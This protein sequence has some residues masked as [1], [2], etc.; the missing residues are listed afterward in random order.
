M[1]EVLTINIESSSV[2]VAVVRGRRML[3]WAEAP[4]PQGVVT[5]G[6]V[7]D[8]A[9]VSGVLGKLLD[10]I[11]ARRI[12]PIIGVSGLRSFYRYLTVPKMEK[13][14]L[15]KVVLHDLEDSVHV[16]QDQLYIN[17]ARVRGAGGDSRV[18]VVASPRSV[19]DSIIQTVRM[20]GLKMPVLDCKPLAL[21]RLA[22]TENCIMVDIEADSMQFVVVKKR[23]PM[24]IR[25]VPLGNWSVTELS[26]QLREEVDTTL[27]L[28][29]SAYPDDPV[30][31][32][33][34]VCI[35]GAGVRGIE[36]VKQLSDKL[37]RHVE[38]VT[39]VLN[40]L[41]G[42]P[43]PDYAVNMGLAMRPSGRILSGHN[44]VPLVDILPA[45]Y[46]PAPRP[47]KQLVLGPAVAAGILMVALSYQAYEQALFR[48]ELAA[49]E[50]KV[51]QE[52]M[53][54]KQAEAKKLNDLQQVLAQTETAL[55]TVQAERNT[56]VPEN[57]Q[58]IGALG[59]IYSQSGDQIMLCTVS[60]NGGKL[61]I[62]GAALDHRSVLNYAERLKASK[63]FTKIDIRESSAVVLSGEKEHGIYRFGAGEEARVLVKGD[64]VI[65]FTIAAAK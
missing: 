37:Q 58:F 10:S 51:V 20:A 9:A 8:P 46:R 42:M 41:D 22:G 57:P 28:Y 32:G 26:E 18:F 36:S 40:H 24:V 27:R 5:G 14:L 12:R 54:L 62:S 6:V 39:P 44:S 3:R 1:L 49:A 45:A 21:A 48:S 7:V 53:R 56:L 23:C 61:L 16:P 43:W 33:M 2:R 55:R 59:A 52:E 64:T 34:S 63:A 11:K 15:N 29:E 31:S 13:A 4:L 60:Q 25:T 19:I 65:K 38:L 50:V 47:V 35:S 17:W 30:T